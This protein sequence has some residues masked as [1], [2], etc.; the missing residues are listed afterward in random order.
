MRA[1]VFSDCFGWIH[2]APGD[3]GVVLCGAQGFEQF[4]AHAGWRK[5]AA[6]IAAQGFPVLR[7]DYHGAGDS[8]GT[9][10]D[11]DRL[12]TWQANVADAVATLR[13][14]TGIT[15]VVLVGLRLGALL[16][17]DYAAKTGDVDGL[18]LL[19]PVPT[20]RSYTRE[21][22][23]FARMADSKP[24]EAGEIEMMGFR[25]TAETI[26]A[27]KDFRPAA[28][29]R[30]L[31]RRLLI[32][33]QGP[34]GTILDE[35]QQ[36]GAEITEEAFP[37]YTE[38]LAEPSGPIPEGAFQR[39]VTWLGTCETGTVAKSGATVPPSTFATATFAEE[40]ILFGPDGSLF[41]MLCQ[42]ASGPCAEVMLLVNAGNNPHI[43]W[44]RSNVRIARDLAARGIAS[45]RIDVAGIGDS[46]AQAGR[47]AQIP[48]SAANVGDVEAALDVLQAR[49]LTQITIAGSCSGAHLALQS[50]RRDPRVG[51]VVLIN[52]FSYIW[53]ESNDLRA[54]TRAAGRSTAAYASRFKSRETWLRLLRG[55]LDLRQ[56]SRTF[57]ARIRHAVAVRLAPLNPKSHVRQ[58]RSWFDDLAARQIGVLFVF[59][60]GDNSL[61]MF[62]S[63]L[64]EKRLRRN[65]RARTAMLHGAD[66]HL[67]DRKSQDRLA[68][69]LVGMTASNDRN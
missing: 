5:L 22:S 39:V 44:A 11:P 40:P 53:L 27:L 24:A 23:A 17:M 10:E 20:G 43:G 60:E 49:G 19:A 66:H 68:D 31:A 12:A 54:L 45:F 38:F 42:P 46:P 37:G 57:A 28:V 48:F 67:T 32:L 41:G 2:E 61:D 62:N 36:A 26:A 18:V 47:P 16:A 15:R 59:S 52:L 65:P 9:D 56:L 7:F 69:L 3:C 14:E 63:N 25:L 6:D 64:G 30:P 1:L 33:T 58:I 13:R 8:L 35:A 55:D 50:V 21:I 34:R 4:C 51:A 29:A